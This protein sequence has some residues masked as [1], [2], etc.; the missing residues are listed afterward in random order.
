[1]K[2]NNKTIN[3]KYGQDSSALT[4]PI[5]TK[6][7]L[8]EIRWKKSGNKFISY[9]SSLCCHIPDGGEIHCLDILGGIQGIIR[10]EDAEVLSK[11]IN[12]MLL[13]QPLN[14]SEEEGKEDNSDAMFTVDKESDNPIL[15]EITDRGVLI[16]PSCSCTNFS[17]DRAYAFVEQN[18]VGFVKSSADPIATGATFAVLE[19]PVIIDDADP[20]LE[21]KN[22]GESFTTD[23]AIKHIRWT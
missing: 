9:D 1:M 18:I 12:S 21:C 23:A 8:E 4:N 10:C 16:C 5:L 19:S 17:Y 20:V 3:I 15:K 11:I 13:V 2:T 7:V 14:K 6:T 22:C